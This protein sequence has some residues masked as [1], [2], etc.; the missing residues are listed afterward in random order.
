[1]TKIS[2]KPVDIIRETYEPSHYKDLN[3][4]RP[5]LKLKLR[6]LKLQTIYESQKSAIFQKPKILKLTCTALCSVYRSDFKPGCQRAYIYN[7][8][9]LCAYLA[10]LN[11][12]NT[13]KTKQR[14]GWPKLTHG[15]NDPEALYFG[16]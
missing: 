13:S 11:D 6:N 12:N 16:T 2:F 10:Y 8:T 3:Q 7:N 5:A 15:R 1:M 9:C 4:T 14:L